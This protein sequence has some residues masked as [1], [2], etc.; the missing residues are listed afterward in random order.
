MVWEAPFY[1]MTIKQTGSPWKKNSVACQFVEVMES[2]TP[3]SL[4][5]SFLT[6]YETSR[7]F[8]IKEAPLL[9]FAPVFL[10]LSLTWK[11][12]SPLNASPCGRG[13]DKE[14][15]NSGGRQAAPHLHSTPQR[16]EHLVSP[17]KFW[18]CN[19]PFWFLLPATPL[20]PQILGPEKAGRDN[21]SSTSRFARLKSPSQEDSV[22]RL[23]ELWKEDQDIFL[24][25]VCLPGLFLLCFP[26]TI[27]IEPRICVRH[28]SKRLR[29]WLKEN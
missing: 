18:Y 15:T 5:D 22:M 26:F 2:F 27:I 28:C 19:I 7:K 11:F 13:R 6:E 14:L 23:V 16:V 3:I 12:F 17:V 20:S 1:R 21:T 8:S 24:L 9:L 10:Q 25:G 29:I 4:A